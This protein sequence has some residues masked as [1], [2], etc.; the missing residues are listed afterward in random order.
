MTGESTL[1]GGGG[2]YWIPGHLVI[3]LLGKTVIPKTLKM[4]VVPACM[5]LTMKYGPQNVTGEPGV[6][7]M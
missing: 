1:G 4:G 3:A 6:S 5:V 7:I 2:S